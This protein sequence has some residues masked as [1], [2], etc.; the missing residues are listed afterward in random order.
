LLGQNN[1]I[2]MYGKSRNEDLEKKKK[3]KVLIL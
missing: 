3:K 2:T 1:D